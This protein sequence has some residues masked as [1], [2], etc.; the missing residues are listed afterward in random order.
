MQIEF[1]NRK[2]GEYL[3]Q[4][5][6]WEAYLKYGDKFPSYIKYLE[7]CYREITGGANL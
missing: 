4:H 5:E 6:T 3:T 2:T 7:V 1:K